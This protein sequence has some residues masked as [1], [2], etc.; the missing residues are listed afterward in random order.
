LAEDRCRHRSRHPPPARRVGRE[1]GQQLAADRAT[2]RS[3]RDDDVHDHAAPLD[4]DD[5]YDDHHHH[6]DDEPAGAEHPGAG[7]AASDD[8]GAAPFELGN[9]QAH[10]SPVHRLPG[11]PAVVDDHRPDHNQRAHDDCA[12]DHDVAPHD[13][14][15]SD[16][17]L[18]AHDHVTAD[19]HHTPDDHHD[20]PLKLRQAFR[21]RRR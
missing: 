6:H 10:H 18:A 8:R 11:G 7:T 2:R 15:T 20:H 13:D 16:H 19:D 5:R 14:V 21:R 12:P 3:V 4:S 1:R 9:L 17:D